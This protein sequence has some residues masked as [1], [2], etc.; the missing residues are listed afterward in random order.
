MY[1][2]ASPPRDRLPESRV[3]LRYLH[4]EAHM[5][6]TRVTFIKVTFLIPQCRKV[7]RY[8]VR[9]WRWDDLYLCRQWTG[10]TWGHA[11]LPM[12]TGW[13]CQQKDYSMVGRGC[14]FLGISVETE[15][16]LAHTRISCWFSRIG[17]AEILTFEYIVLSTAYIQTLHGLRVVSDSLPEFRVK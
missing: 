3:T 14:T 1:W 9:E 15:F 8:S 17:E 12:I 11:G 5:E 7:R 6:S 13:R 2:P 4:A 10:G 16:C